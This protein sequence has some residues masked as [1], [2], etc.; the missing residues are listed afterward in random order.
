[1][2]DLI[3]EAHVNGLVL[4]S[5]IALICK[6]DSAVISAVPSKFFLM[7]Q[8]YT[9]FLNDKAVIIDQNPII[10]D[11]VPGEMSI[12]FS[13]SPALEKDYALFCADA[14]CAVLKIYAGENFDEA[15]IAFTNFFTPVIAAGGIVRNFNNE[16][17]FIKRLGLWDLPKGKLNKNETKTDGA[18]REVNE[19]TGLV[20]LTITKQLPSTFHIYTDRKGNDVLKET[21]WFEMYCDRQQQLVPQ[22]EEDITEV[23]WFTKD[24]LHIPVNHTYASL[25]NLLEDYLSQ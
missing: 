20:N 12:Y 24:E 13:G 16:Y 14:D 19:E 6:S 2:G 11:L 21:Y 23:R 3:P 25:R 4:S 7:A 22:L 5:L 9:V 8:R 18:I 1:M 10:S 17:L 15:C